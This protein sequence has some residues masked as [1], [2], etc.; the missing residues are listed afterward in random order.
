MGRAFAVH[1]DLRLTAAMDRTCVH[2]AD[3][4]QA[5]TALIGRAFPLAQLLRRLARLE[6]RGLPLTR[7]PS[8]T[9]WD[10]QR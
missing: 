4:P 9:G 6:S 3:D 10:E 7:T 1:D 2:V 5:F 8:R